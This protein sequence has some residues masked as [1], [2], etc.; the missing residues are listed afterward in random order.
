M[1]MR[2]FAVAVTFLCLLAVVALTGV[3]QAHVNHDQASASNCCPEAP[4]CV[5]GADCCVATRNGEPASY[6]V[7]L[8]KTRAKAQGQVAD[9]CVAKAACCEAKAACC[10]AEADCCQAN[11]PC[12]VAGAACCK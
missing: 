6:A 2:Y 12:C 5:P 3:S 10:S 9:C 4:C 1:S 11:L 7:A 8:L